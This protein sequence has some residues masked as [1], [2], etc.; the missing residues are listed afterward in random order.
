M[1]EVPLR[2]N[3]EERFFLAWLLQTHLRPA[4]RTA[5]SARRTTAKKMTAADPSVSL[6]SWFP[7][8][9]LLAPNSH[10]R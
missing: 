8:D 4:A 2:R 9:R 3:F 10:L 7:H 6:V 5:P 1:S